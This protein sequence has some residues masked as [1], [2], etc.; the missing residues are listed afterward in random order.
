MTWQAAKAVEERNPED[1]SRFSLRDTTY[2]GAAASSVR[3]LPR[4]RTS[5]PPPNAAD[6]AEEGVSILEDLTEGAEVTVS[7][8]QERAAYLAQLGPDGTE[9]YWQASANAVEQ[10]VRF[11]C[12]TEAARAAAPAPKVGKKRNTERF[13]WLISGT[14][15]TMVPV[16][17]VESYT[18]TSVFSG[19]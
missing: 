8:G 5:A 18:S 7:S 11:D 1:K 15:K 13:S 6:A 12:R 3:Q 19:K 9:A 14:T 17:F 4:S 16:L 10:W 2:L